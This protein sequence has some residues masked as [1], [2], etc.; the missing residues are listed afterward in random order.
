MTVALVVRP[1]M[2]VFKMLPCLKLFPGQTD[3]KM[4]LT[5]LLPIAVCA[6]AVTLAQD[7]DTIVTNT[8]TTS[9]DTFVTTIVSTST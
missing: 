6:L 4:K 9:T 2:G 8:V 1:T 7:S 3:S 5:V